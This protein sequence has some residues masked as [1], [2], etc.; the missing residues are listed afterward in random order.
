P[1]APV[2]VLEHPRRARNPAVA[3]AATDLQPHPRIRHQVAH[4]SGL[5]PVLGDDPERVA[6]QP[7]AH[8][9]VAGTAALAADGLEQR[10]AGWREADPQRGLDRRGEGVLLQG[11]GDAS[12]HR[13]SG[14]LLRNVA[15]LARPVVFAIVFSPVAMGTL[16]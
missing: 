12:L 11:V 13:E 4:V 8:R 2:V 7:V 1:H 5:P 15:L 16:L 10:V 14:T 9:S 3:K 6:H